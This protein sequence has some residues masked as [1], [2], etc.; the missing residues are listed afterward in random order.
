MEPTAFKLLW[1]VSPATAWTSAVETVGEES[2]IV[3]AI[4]TG[5]LRCSETGGVDQDSLQEFLVQ[6]SSDQPDSALTLRAYGTITAVFTKLS[7][8]Q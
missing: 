7:S 2:A 3:L 1:A 5:V 8:G 6:I 4:K